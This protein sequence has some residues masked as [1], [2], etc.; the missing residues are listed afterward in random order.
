MREPREQAH[1]DA[2]PG[3]GSCTLTHTCTP[4]TQRAA[5]DP[6]DVHRPMELPTKEALLDAAKRAQLLYPGPVGEL[7]HQELVSWLQFG[8]LLGSALIFRVVDEL[9]QARD[10]SSTSPPTR[11]DGAPGRQRGAQ[12]RAAP[13]RLPATARSRVIT[14]RVPGTPMIS[15][16]EP[17][18]PAVLR[19]SSVLGCCCDAA[20][21]AH[22]GD[23]AQ[24]VEPEGRA[25]SQGKCGDG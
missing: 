19:P 20:R 11:A 1:R 3:P 22:S 16:W 8:H 17:L 18:P 6:D 9:N 21:V 15:A 2:E 24:Y 23:L 14:H 5:E 25:E 13:P 12:H 4:R 7:L 10:P